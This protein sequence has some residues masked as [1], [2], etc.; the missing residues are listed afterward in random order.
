MSCFL[1]LEGIEGESGNPW[2]RGEID[3]LSA[4]RGYRIPNR[5][6]GGFAISGR[7]LGDVSVTKKYNEDSSKLVQAAASGKNFK[8]GLITLESKNK[9]VT[10]EMTNVSIAA[11][12]SDKS[13]ET[14][15]LIY[16]PPSN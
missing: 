3:I 8:N 2:H 4:V 9:V 10:L 16:D 6:M 13:V 15:S 14:I 11:F 12:S 7:T 5:H 1:W